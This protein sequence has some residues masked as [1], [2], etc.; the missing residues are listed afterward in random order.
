MFLNYEQSDLLTEMSVLRTGYYTNSNGNTS[1]GKLWLLGYNNCQLSACELRTAKTGV[2]YIV[3]ELKRKPVNVDGLKTKVSF[4]PHTD[5]LFTK[6]LKN[7]LAGFDHVL[8]PKPPDMDE[9]TYIRH[10]KNRVDT[11]IGQEIKVV[12]TYSYEPRR[13]KYGYQIERN[14]YYDETYKVFD[15]RMNVFY[16]INRDLDWRKISSIFTEKL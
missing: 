3:I 5:I 10:V 9:N 11:L 12:V 15:W 16:N 8:K 1:Q 13:D 7:F 6:D 4:V 14:K 2:H